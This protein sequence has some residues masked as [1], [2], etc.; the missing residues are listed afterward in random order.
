MQIIGLTGSIAMGKTTAANAFR[1]QGV[2]V[3]DSDTVVHKLLGPDGAA[4]VVAAVE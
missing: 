1:R 3:H 4:A 2:L